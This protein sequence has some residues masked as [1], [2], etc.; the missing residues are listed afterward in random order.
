VT[1]LQWDLAGLR[2]SGEAKM[3]EI[4]A[5]IEDSEEVRDVVAGLEQQY[6]AFHRPEPEDGP[7][8]PLAEER[9]LPTGEEIGA[10]FER[11]LAGLDRRDRPDE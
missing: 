3:L 4:A 11:F 9:E 2:S 10:E 6:D 5:Q 7:E 8:L 1:G